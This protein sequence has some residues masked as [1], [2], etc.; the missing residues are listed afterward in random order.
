MAH[1]IVGHPGYKPCMGFSDDEMGSLHF[2]CFF[3]VL[4]TCSVLSELVSP[5]L[6]PYYSNLALFDDSR[7]QYYIAGMFVNI[8]YFDLLLLTFLTIESFS[9]SLEQNPM[10]C[11]RLLDG[12]P[13][14]LHIKQFQCKLMFWL[15]ICPSRDK[16]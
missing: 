1:I 12:M 3:M 7:W 16:L 5:S 9:W 14:S 13:V 6:A 15:K 10:H 8:S 11:K 2:S 4:Y